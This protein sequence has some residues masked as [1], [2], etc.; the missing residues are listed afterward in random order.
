[1]PHDAAAASTWFAD[2]KTL[3]KV[4]LGVLPPLV[5]ILILAGGALFAMARMADTSSWVDHT[6]KVLKEGQS[7]LSAAVDMETGMRGYLLAGREEFL[8][9]YRAGAAD[10][11][12][13]L[14]ELRL[15]VSDNPPQVA[16]LQEAEEVLRRWQ[17]DVAEA[18]IALRREIG[19]APSMNDL[20]AEV[21]KARGRPSST[22]FARRSQRSSRPKRSFSSNV[23]QPSTH[24]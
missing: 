5:L 24:S 9:P 13:R 20:A 15:T 18:Q 8:E 6:R 1:M 23:E 3:T 22:R 11:Y 2:R 7:V 12:A 16:R 14:N 17:E 19:D 21:A 4:L 10:A